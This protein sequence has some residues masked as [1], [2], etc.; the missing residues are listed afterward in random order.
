LW[1]SGD[2]LLWWTKASPAPPLVITG[3]SPVPTELIISN[4]MKVPTSPGFQGLQSI[5]ETEGSL[6]LGNATATLFGNNLG[7]TVQSG[8]RIIV[9]G[10]LDPDQTLG[11]EARY[12][13][14]S[15]QPIHYSAASN[16]S[17]TLAIPFFD[18][19][20]VE[21][22]YPVAQLAQTVITERSI[23]T[24]P[25]VFVHISTTTTL[26]AYSG[27]VT[28][29]SVNS[30][31]GAEANAVYNVL[32]VPNARVDLLAGFRWVDLEES[33][34]LSSNVTHTFSSTTVYDRALGLP[35]GKIPLLNISNSA[36]TRGDSFEAHNN[37]Y[38]GQLG[39][40][41]SWGLGRFSVM[42]DAQ[43][44]F[45]VME[46]TMDLTGTT[47]F[48]TTTTATPVKEIRLAGIP[49][50]V[51][52]GAPNTTQTATGHS[53]SGLFIPPGG[54]GHFSRNVFAVIPEG[55]LQVSYQITDRISASVGY[56][57]LY[58]STVA[59]AADQVDR[60]VYPSTLTTPPST[61][62]STRPI[63]FHATDDWAQGLNFGLQ[64]RF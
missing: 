27:Y 10:W 40:R 46:E 11:A 63:Q 37:F 58:L 5:T 33:L 14:L 64:F 53:A 38:G 25:A 30:W 1:V 16:G 50:W 61:A 29:R 49:I 44:A 22:S 42:A 47:S 34:S 54:A 18:P 19:A 7:T 24:T 57:F 39:G 23:N 3:A 13:F 60:A 9:G 21:S 4:V 41:A 20:G 56:T 36:V 45:G 8:G 59:R 26:D 12:F 2:Y 48:T 35:T 31:Q 17:P 43:V 52:T 51:A 28:G 32:R 55:Q 62:P 15:P 6:T